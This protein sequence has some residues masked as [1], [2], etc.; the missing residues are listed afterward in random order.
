[1]SYE[2]VVKLTCDRC[3]KAKRADDASDFDDWGRVDYGRY[4]SVGDEDPYKHLCPACTKLF[5][6]FMGE[7]E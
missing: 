1:M 3:G 7:G 2:H 5:L 6:A 4:N